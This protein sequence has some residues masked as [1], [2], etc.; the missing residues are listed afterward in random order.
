MSSGV[1]LVLAI[2]GTSVALTGLGIRMAIDRVAAE[3]RRV[4]E[5]I[6]HA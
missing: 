6:E 3:V 2:L 4:A 1:M 5:A